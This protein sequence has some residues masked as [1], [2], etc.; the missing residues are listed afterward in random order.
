LL[1]LLCVISLS[2]SAI[3][4][5]NQI[6]FAQAL[7]ILFVLIIN[8]MI[9][10]LET[11]LKHKEIHHKVRSLLDDIRV[12]LLNESSDQLEQWKTEQHYPHLYLPDTPCI[13]LQITFRDDRL[14]HLPTSLLV[15]NDVVLLS[16][17]H[18]APA[19]CESVIRD[20]NR[21]AHSIKL[22]KGEL[23]KPTIDHGPSASHSTR[24]R[25]RCQASPFRLLQTPYL[26]QLRLA[27]NR[28]CERSP[29][30][31]EQERYVLMVKYVQFGLAP[32]LFAASFSMAA[33][34]QWSLTNQFDVNDLS[35]HE[36]RISSN[37]SE[38]TAMHP[39]S[40]L[41]SVLLLISPLIKACLAILPLLPFT[42]PL[43]WLLLN[44]YGY[45]K[46]QLIAQ[47][48]QTSADKSSGTGV[49]LQWSPAPAAN[50]RAGRYSNPMDGASSEQDKFYDY[51]LETNSMPSESDRIEARIDVFQLAGTVIQLLC[52]KEQNHLWR[53]GN[54][55]HVLGSITTLCCVDKKGILSTPNPI[56]DKIFFLN[57]G[58]TA[59]NGT[60]A[61]LSSNKT[62][63]AEATVGKKTHNRKSKLSRIEVLDVTPDCASSYGIQ[64]DDPNWQRFL[65]NLKPLGLAILLN[66]C[67]ASAQQEYARFCDHMTNESLQNEASLPVVRKRC[68]CE[69]ARR[70]GF[71]TAATHDYTYLTQLGCFRQ[72]RPEV[73]QQGRLAK[74]LR[75]PRLKLP[76]PNMSCAV[77]RDTCSNSCFFFS[78]GSGDLVL[79]A[80]S[81]FWNGD[82]LCPLK[83]ADRKHILDF[84]QRTS[85][86]DSCF[87]FSYSPLAALPDRS[88]INDHYAEF[89]PDSSHVFGSQKPCRTVDTCA[90]EPITPNTFDSIEMNDAFNVSNT[91]GHVSTC[92]ALNSIGPLLSQH[93][94][95]DSLT[96]KES[97]EEF[98]RPRSSASNHSGDG[99]LM[100]PMVG[101]LTNQVFLGLVTLQYHACADFVRLIE[102][103]EKACV[104]FVHFSK[105]NELRSRVFSEKMGLE[106]GWNCHISLL[107][108][109]NGDETTSG[110][111]SGNT[112]EGRRQRQSMYGDS[113]ELLDGQGNTS[114]QCPSPNCFLMRS[115]SAPSY[116]NLQTGMTGGSSQFSGSTDRLSTGDDNG[117][118]S[119]T[120]ETSKNESNE[121]SGQLYEQRTAA[122]LS[123]SP[124]LSRATESSGTDQSPVPIA[125]DISNRAKLPK[126]IENIR[127]HLENV[128][129]VPLLVSLFTD[130]TPDTTVQMIRIM[131]EYGE[132][133]GVLG[134]SANFSNMP[135]FLQADTSISVEP[136]FPHLCTCLPSWP[137][138]Q[139]TPEYLPNKSTLC[140]IP[141]L[142]PIELSNRLNSLPCSL[143]LKREE[144]A[145]LIQLIGHSR[146]FMINVRNSLQFYLC[147]CLSLSLAQFGADAA[148]LPSL[149]STGQLLWLLCLQ[150]PILSLS[151]VA[152]Q[153]Q[154]QL[155]TLATGKNL[156]LSKESIYYFLICYLIKFSLS[157]LI[158]IGSFS[159][160]IFNFC[161]NFL[162]IESTNSTK[163]WH[164]L[165]LKFVFIFYFFFALY[166]CSCD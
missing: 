105:E 98:A 51:E 8:L 18:S 17:G 85:L 11:K 133:V 12:H 72:I 68:L 96:V 146:H 34:Q 76:M 37:S 83:E 27:L 75:L 10:G 88:V 102:R 13:S 67:N 25:K 115:Q 46:L 16:P 1:I 20:A 97:G 70:V 69:L 136:L 117:R 135:I 126:G 52:A 158:L 94:S 81:E 48:K 78:H 6:L 123:I 63:G 132:V 55:L 120:S 149:F 155:M 36:F 26:E 42:S 54:L 33:F 103:L 100:E 116:M 64:F 95:T 141:P 104:R 108:D 23:Y 143:R 3:Q 53:S 137:A 7:F 57:S 118:T 89:A 131:Q 73:V 130:C 58:S 74:S 107:S 151:L 109:A 38:T 163:C 82:D 124:S 77:I 119:R 39:D 4:E 60:S 65:P 49:G 31:Y 44:A 56:P 142:T 162:P 161:T 138:S 29:T 125:F 35:A 112:A 21:T 61:N 165:D 50:M 71:T 22:R 122:E 134:S 19:D 86:T 41:S 59:T 157:A 154:T 113:S 24:L 92:S 128:D 32:L 84:Y 166:C 129:N 90:H 140:N 106:S 160:L 101:Q 127:P 66:T 28:S 2:I 144:C 40:N 87:A 164:P 156:N 14:V 30:A 148:M 15:Q 43:T 93:L 9:V 80:C 139:T 121:E 114:N 99:L 152:S 79:D 147:C 153:P 45:A 47:A 5:S 145:A 110:S 159:L 111:T 150:L 91:P 62:E